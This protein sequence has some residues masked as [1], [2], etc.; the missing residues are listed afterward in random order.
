MSF[1]SSWTFL[2][3]SAVL[4]TFFPKRPNRFLSAILFN[5]LKDSVATMTESTARPLNTSETVAAGTS[6]LPNVKKLSIEGNIAVGKSTFLNLLGKT[7]QGWH[8]VTEPVNKWQ[9]IQ[10]SSAHSSTGNLLQMVYEDPSR[11]SYLFQTYS[12]M[13]RFKSQLEPLSEQLIKVQNPV[14]VFERS[15]YS[16]RYVF[17]KSLFD[18]GVLS[19]IEWTI[20][21]DWHS[22]LLREFEERVALNGILY[23]QATPEKCYERLQHRGRL[24]EKEVEL[25]YLE[26]LHG[27]HE[28]WLIEKSTDVH[29]ENMKN[30]PVLVLD[31]NANFHNNP[32]EEESLIN[33]VKTFIETL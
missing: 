1:S 25:G 16:D 6:K 22:F 11:W 27:Q 19:E 24:E 20:Y 9:S 21:Q 32:A 15:V 4:P 29:F 14:Q 30:I 7:F 8:M 3:T 33:K 17:A 13:S 10:G 5:C 12:C 31:V 28:R 23:L 18:L 26:R 2:K